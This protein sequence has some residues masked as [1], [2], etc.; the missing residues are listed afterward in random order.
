MKN[1]KSEA[2][3][4][5]LGMAIMGF[6]IWLGL[7][8]ISKDV[9]TVNVKGL[10]EMEVKADRVFWPI[11]IKVVGNDLIT[12]YNEVNAK[13]IIVEKF[14]KDNGISESEISINAP[15]VQDREADYYSNNNYNTRYNVTSTITVSS[16]NIDLV[17]NLMSRQGELIKQGV[18]I[19][20]GD[21]Y[22]D[23]VSFIYSDLNSIKPQM[24][25]E[26]TK[27]ARAAAEKFAFDSNSKL[28]KIKTATQGQF[29]ISD[30]DDNTPYIKTVRVVTNV[31]YFLED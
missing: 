9:R 23:H 2:L 4:L 8:H 27:N 3:F 30:R 21:F 31:T 22:T 11:T 14:L 29:S 24:I 18:A 1:L 10:A 5:M 13:N 6:F 16:S 7:S 25:E 12:V 15:R 28:G 26:A 20:N 17:R 19:A